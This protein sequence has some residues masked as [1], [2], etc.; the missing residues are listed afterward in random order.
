MWVVEMEVQLEEVGAGDWR[1][2]DV[3]GGLVHGDG[4]T[5]GRWWWSMPA[6]DIRTVGRAYIAAIQGALLSF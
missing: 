2:G 5:T 1:S 4:V 3:A 6:S